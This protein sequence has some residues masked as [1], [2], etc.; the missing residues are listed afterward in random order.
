MLHYCEMEQYTV[1]KINKDAF[2]CEDPGC[3]WSVFSTQHLVRNCLKY[4]FSTSF[5]QKILLFN[6]FSTFCV[7]R[8]SSVEGCIANSVCV[9]VCCYAHYGIVKYRPSMLS[10]HSDLSGQLSTLTLPLMTSVTQ[11]A[12]LWLLLL[13]HTEYTHTNLYTHTHSQHLLNTLTDSAVNINDK[14]YCQP[15]ERTGTLQRVRIL[16]MRFLL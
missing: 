16:L 1:Q 2:R 9:C 11:Y 10:F 8:V 6:V 12:H 4:V 7:H 15:L 3:L 5:P 14:A 13:V